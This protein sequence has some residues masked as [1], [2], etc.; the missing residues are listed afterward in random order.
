MADDVDVSNSPTSI[1][2]DIPVRTIE[3]VSGKHIQVFTQGFCLPDYDYLAVAYPAADTET[4][5]FKTG[6]AGG[7]TVGLL[8][9]VYAD[10]TKENLLTVTLT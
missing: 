3:N 9:V 10:S 4:Y 7:T 5:T 8:T 1:N 2:T 6:G